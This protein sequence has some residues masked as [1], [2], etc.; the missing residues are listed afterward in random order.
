M[1]KIKI[2]KVL[3]DQIVTERK[4][5]GMTQ[6]GLAKALKQHQSWVSR[7]ERGERDIG[8]EEFYVLAGVIGFAPRTVLRKVEQAISCR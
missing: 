8:V 1:S 3:I 4:K 7:L 2:H 5:A 6:V